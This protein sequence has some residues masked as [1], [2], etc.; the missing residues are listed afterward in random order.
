MANNSALSN[1][2]DHPMCSI[3]IT[4]GPYLES[5]NDTIF[6][7]I[8]LPSF[9]LTL[10]M[11]IIGGPG[12]SL[13]FYIYFAKWR[14]TTARIFILA[15]AGFD[16]MNCFFTM[17]M[18]MAVLANIIMFDIGPVCKVF[19][20]ITFM[21]NNGS[22]VV[23]AGI[24]I[25][26]YIRICMP[27]KPQLRP[28]QAKYVVVA[29]LILAVLFAW[30]ALL[31]YGIQTYP[32]P[33]PGKPY[34]C[35]IGKICLYEEEYL[36]TDYPLIFTLALLIGNLIIDL[37]MIILYSMIGYQVIKRGNA[38]EPSPST[39][40]RKG[41]TS[42]ENTDDGIIVSPGRNEDDAAQKPLNNADDSVFTNE[43]KIYTPKTSEKPKK[44]ITKQ[45]SAQSIKRE[46]FRQRSLSIASIESRRAQ[47]YKTTLMLFM[48]TI[49]FMGSFIP[50]CTISIIRAINKNYYTDLSTSGKAVYNLFLRTY[51]LSSSLNPVIYCFLSVQ[52]RN[53][54][55]A[56]F[57][58]IKAFCSGRSS[59]M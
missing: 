27:L 52:F 1:S 43:P 57:K 50:Y 56:L 11:F 38:V 55:K 36:H 13:V 20:Y 39:K 30:P 4:E 16:M 12:N 3:K 35:I 48:V 14:K 26:R 54:C 42:T 53:E 15:L 18:E 45:A 32:I 49:L 8:Y 5:A 21:M 59:T 44:K 34:I 19:R 10:I 2:S 37:G 33:V 29:A 22:S 41:S 9:V 46:A 51:M 47:M 7:N 17:P 6:K 40:W 31:M 24:A 28:T 23:L 58:Q 25:D